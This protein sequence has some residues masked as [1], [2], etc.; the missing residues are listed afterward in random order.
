MNVKGYEVLIDKQ[1]EDLL[2]AYSWHV[3]SGYVVRTGLRP[4]RNRY[5]LHNAIYE[6]VIERALLPG[7]LVDHKDINPLNNRRDNLRLV[8]QTLNNANR[9]I[10]RN[11]KTGYKGVSLYAGKYKAQATKNGEIFYL[12][13]FTNPVEAARAYNEK[14][15]ELFGEFARLNDIDS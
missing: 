3:N 5:A 15:F 2:A 11:N 7:E 14:A 1:D 12:G 9:N 4:E 8:D 6:R 13:L 10:G